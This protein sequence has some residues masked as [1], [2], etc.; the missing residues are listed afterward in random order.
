MSTNLNDIGFTSTSAFKHSLNL[1]F[2]LSCLCLHK[3][4]QMNNYEEID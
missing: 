1:N 4:N 2:T 3:K